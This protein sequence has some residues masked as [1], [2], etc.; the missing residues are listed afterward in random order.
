VP[1]ASGAAST[2]PLLERER[3][4]E[5]I[6]VAL[7]QARGGMGAVILLEGTAGLGKTELV[8]AVRRRGEDAGMQASLARGSELER[9][10]AFGVVR[11][12][13]EPVVAANEVR[14]EEVFSG[15]AAVARPLFGFE[16][17][18]HGVRSEDPAT[19]QHGLYWLCATLARSRPLLLLVDDAH[20]ADLASLRFLVY[21]AR[22]LEGL[23]LLLLLAARPAETAEEEYLIHLATDPRTI[24]LSPRPLS[25]DAVAALLRAE[26]GQEPE[27]PFVEACHAATGGPPFLVRELIRELALRGL[28]PVAASAKPVRDLGPRSV[29]RSVVARARAL[30]PGGLALA[31]AVAVLGTDGE[32]H[33][34]ARLADVDG[35][36]A[37]DGL[38]RLAAA[39]VLSPGPSIEFA[40]PILRAAVYGE[41]P[42]RERSHLH[43]RAARLLAEEGSPGERVAAQ[44]L[45]TDPAGDADTVDLLLRVAETALSRGA[46]ASAVSYLRRAVK[47]PP[48]SSRRAEVLDRLGSAEIQAGHLGQATEHL[49]EA[50]GLAADS[51]HGIEIARHLAAA[52]SIQGRY[53]ESGAV[54]G[55]LLRTTE[56][57][58]DLALALRGEL[59]LL[60]LFEP[61]IRAEVDVGV[62][63]IDPTPD[64]HSPGARAYL[65]ALALDSTLRL[66]PAAEVLALCERAREAGIVEEIASGAIAW[67]QVLFPLIF[68]DGFG[69]AERM[70]AEAVDHLRERP[71]VVGS[72]RAHL[73]RS[74]VHLRRGAL[75]EAIADARIAADAA[76]DASFVGYPIAVSVM[77]DALVQ[78][79][80]AGAAEKVLEDAGMTG[81]VP[82]TFLHSWALASRA[83]LR[84]AQA[85]VD[86]AIADFEQ[87][88]RRV[89]RFDQ[90]NPATVG[91]GSGFALALLR[92]GNRQRAVALAERDV[93]LARRW[94]TPRTSGVSLRALGLCR[95]GTEGIELLRESVDALEGSGARLEHA[96]SLIDLGAA[97]RRSG[98]R[99]EARE[100]L[101]A[102]MELA[103]RCGAVALVERAREELLATGA[104]PRRIMRTGI[105]AL[106][107]S[108]LR[109]ARMAAEGMTNREIAE[110]LFVTERTVEGH[111]THTFQKLEITSRGGLPDRFAAE[112]GV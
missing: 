49:A 28:S 71:S 37:D 18:P 104:R 15:A 58:P 99:A 64:G 78:R 19:V 44:L 87:L 38:D 95:G 25:G 65:S 66:R 9:E 105:D 82:E 88:G 46:P 41:I 97:V 12:L 4:I 109:V 75:R 2:E 17:G 8:T 14:R 55:D 31:R 90:S 77:V 73:A 33:R 62:G 68:A 91:Y 22:R 20:W 39:G 80:E 29:A 102:G 81:E 69:L 56:R 7:A 6:D 52:L 101:H 42:A 103:H 45:A 11:Q 74:F 10:L 61:A 26:L 1:N 43:L 34:A 85:R 108:E 110:A 24:H 50:R 47:E 35:S 100:P 93:E 30:G 60:G 67:N 79:G 5:R 98:G 21:L 3:E 32:A 27:A 92:R 16:G 59:L 53:G 84:L 57:D 83:A 54:I 96:R 112:D 106:T 72:T 107:P 36:V 89:D 23:K 63:G 13:L 40:H 86:D 94:G 51:T 76:Q 48:D 111:L 70:V